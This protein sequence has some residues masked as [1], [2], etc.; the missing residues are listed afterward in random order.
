M[1]AT[2]DI[3]DELY[4]RLRAAADAQG[5]NVADLVLEAVEVV[6]TSAPLSIP[7]RRR[8]RLPLIDSGR[9]GKLNIPDDIAFLVDAEEDRQR[10]DASLR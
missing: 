9:P 7:E 4:R 6:L 5:R 1:K 2:I 8:I 3:D 10:H